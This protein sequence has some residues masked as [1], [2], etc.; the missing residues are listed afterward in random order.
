MT[1]IIRPSSKELET[2]LGIEYPIL[3]N[4]YI[5]VVDYMGTEDSILSAARRS[6]GKGTKSVLEDRNLLRYLIR[7]FHTSPTE[8]AEIA[9]S[10]DMPI[11][12]ARQFIR[13][14]TANVNEYSARY[15]EMEDIFYV[16]LPENIAVQSKTNK[17]GRGSEGVE[18]KDETKARIRE[19][20][21]ENNEETFARY[22]K[23]LALDL[24]REL[25][26]TVLP[27]NIHTNWT[28]K[29]DVNNLMKF[30]R[31]REDGHAQYEI[32]VYANKMAEIFEL[33]MPNVHEAYIDYIRDAVN[34]S[35]QQFEILKSSI[36]RLED[37][38][39]FDFHIGNKPDRMSKREFD[40]LL[41]LFA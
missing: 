38:F 8:M 6:Y 15:S 11:L 32:R 17:Q 27:V 3:E 12:T 35:K 33:W 16:P 7:H 22:Q 2:I 21:Q 31:L 14:R 5:S 23:L 37:G 26:R 10:M 25:A 28:W 24:S 1:N 34:L 13:H 9:F 30:L 19:I 4:G 18:F 29:I 39:N 40:D 20:I 36:K 41:A